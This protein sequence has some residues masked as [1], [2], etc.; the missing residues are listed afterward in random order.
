MV[1][2]CFIDAASLN[3]ARQKMDEV[4][5]D[6]EAPPFDWAY[7]GE[8]KTFYYDAIPVQV[9]GEDEPTY[10]AR[11]KPKIDELGMI[12]RLPRY[13]VR[14]GDLR[15][16]RRR[17]N[18]QKMVDVQLAVDALLMASRKLFDHCK[19]VTG[20]L[21]FRPLVSALVDMG[22]DV[23]LVYPIHET[24]PDLITSADVAIPFTIHYYSGY[25]PER[26]QIRIPN[27]TIVGEPF[28]KPLNTRV[29]WIDAKCGECAL[30]DASQG[31]IRLL[32]ERHPKALNSR[33][34]V[35]GESV[36]VLKHYCSTVLGLAFP[37]GFDG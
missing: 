20:D 23:D 5:F 37:E 15:H 13:H 21:D 9:A 1:T 18:E 6:G 4:Y 12:E 10:A 36:A 17:G 27:D 30:H 26:F 31:G 33:M 25:I 22:V 35:E 24:N 16:R 8:H 19:I 32:S 11:I 3:M 7:F 2:Y 29:S 14:T 28:Q 34:V